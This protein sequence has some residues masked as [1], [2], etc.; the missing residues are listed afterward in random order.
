MYF[1]LKMAALY[2]TVL[3]K[4]KFFFYR[5]H[6][7]QEYNNRYS[8]IC[9]NYKYLS[10]AR[11]LP[12]FPLDEKQKAFILHKAEFYYVQ[13]LILFMKR[14]KNLKLTVHA[15]SGSGMRF[16]NLVRGIVN[17]ILTKSGWQRFKPLEIEKS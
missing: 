4:K 8:Y 2:P 3:L 16:L 7:G 17:L 10:D 15:L 13:D 9:N 11:N 6:E 12:G 5:V 14:S 1:N